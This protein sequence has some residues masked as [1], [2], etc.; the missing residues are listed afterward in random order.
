MISKG[1]CVCNGLLEHVAGLSFL[2]SFRINHAEVYLISYR[3]KHLNPMFF[4][5][6][7]NNLLLYASYFNKVKR[8]AKMNDRLLKD[9][10]IY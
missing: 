4:Y 3:S 8:G 10:L 5:D 6:L 2:S 7:I 9:N 1:T